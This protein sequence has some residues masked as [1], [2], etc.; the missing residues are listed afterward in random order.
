LIAERRT[1]QGSPPK[2]RRLALSLRES[3]GERAAI[4]VLTEGRRRMELLLSAA[5]TFD[6]LLVE[7][8]PEG[9]GAKALAVSV[10]ALKRCDHLRL[11]SVRRFLLAS[12]R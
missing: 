5:A 4:L 11:K 10:S 8:L 6:R 7:R 1:S 2:L 9:T 3:A 12:A